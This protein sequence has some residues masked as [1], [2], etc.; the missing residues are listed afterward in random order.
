MANLTTTDNVI[1][2]FHLDDALFDNE[3]FTAGGANTYPKGLMLARLTATSKLVPYVTAQ[4]DGSEFPIAVLTNALTTTGSGDTDL[5]AMIKGTVR[6][7][8]L[9]VWTGGSPVAPTVL[10]V[11]LLR[12]FGITAQEDRELLALDNS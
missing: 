8:K 6:K 4:S 12:D 5:R 3:T 7:D 11:D 1:P 10:E 9:L 2:Q